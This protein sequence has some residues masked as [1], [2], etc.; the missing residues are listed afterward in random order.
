M[1]KCLNKLNSKKVLNE[2]ET[3]KYLQEKRKLNVD[4]LYVIHV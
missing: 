1:P 3:P 4:K 2:Y